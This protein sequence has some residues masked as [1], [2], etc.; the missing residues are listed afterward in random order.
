MT[1]ESWEGGSQPLCLSS[2]LALG[3]QSSLLFSL[4][5]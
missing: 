3:A 1:L 2:A 5:E 4:W